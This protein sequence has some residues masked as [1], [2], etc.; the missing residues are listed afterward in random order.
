[1][2]LLFPFFFLVYTD[3][4]AITAVLAT[5]FLALR[6]RYV[7]AG[8]TGF[9]AVLMRQD[10]VI[11]VGMAWMLVVLGETRLDS[12][13]SEWRN[14][15]RAGAVRGLPLLSVLLAFLAFCAWNGG[16]AVGDRV[17]HQVGFN[18]TNIACFLLC[19]WIVFLPQ[20]V[21]AAPEILRLL[22][23]PL[24]IGLLLAGFALHMGTYA[25]RHPFNSEELRFYLHNEVLYWL[26]RY[27]W[28]RA[29]AFVPIAW[30]VMTLCVT[31]VAEPRLHILYL[32]AP[33]S[34]G[35]HPLIEPR[36]YLPAMTLFQVWRPSAG[37]RAEGALLSGY[38]AVASVIMWGIVTER[39]FL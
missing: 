18:P 33:L 37:P 24:C 36:Y 6:G 7:L 13:R 1:M 14:G 9:V 29:I 2:P 35:L 11:W 34:V 4:W 31:R 16:V 8:M 39:F 22:R 25:N 20:N 21:Q 32:V 19:A 26:T 17:R 27:A 30:M 15:L 10:M 3:V 12:W 5:L 23:R 38:V 28:L